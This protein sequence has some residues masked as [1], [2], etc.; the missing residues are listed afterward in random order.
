MEMRRV[1]GLAVVVGGMTC[2]CGSSSSEAGGPTEDAGADSRPPGVPGCAVSTCPQRRAV[3]FGGDGPNGYDQDTWVFDGQ[4][5]TRLDAKGPEGRMLHAM[6]SL[7]DKVVLFGGFADNDV[8]FD[9]TWIFDGKD[10]ARVNAAG[11]RARGGHAMATLGDKVILFGGMRA[12]KNAQHQD[13][14]QFDGV[15]WTRIDGPAPDSR[16]L[17]WMTPVQDKLMLYGGWHG[18]A[19]E[20]GLVVHDTWTFASSW[21]QIFIPPVPA[22]SIRSQAATLNGL[23]VLYGH[24]INNAPAETWTTD[25]QQWTR[26]QAPTPDLIPMGMVTTSSNVVL[27][28]FTDADV[29]ETWTFNGNDWTLH[30]TG[31][32]SKR[33]YSAMAALGTK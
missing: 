27:T 23:G 31:G 12:E 14:W 9:D 17:T 7:G 4:A 28:G 26:I 24:P 16:T 15:T 22:T 18:I 13:T 3:L 11:P 8:A 29:T 21:T 30:S 10:W 32:P 33:H 2:G 25:S 5:W 20:G 1:L 6:A 19:G